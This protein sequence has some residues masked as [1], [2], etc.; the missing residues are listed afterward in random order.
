MLYLD[1]EM[2][3]SRFNRILSLDN[4]LAEHGPKILGMSLRFIHDKRGTADQRE[5]VLKKLTSYWTQHVS[6]WV[7]LYKDCY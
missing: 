4:S 3:D 2:D 7:V 5:Q 6:D 1:T